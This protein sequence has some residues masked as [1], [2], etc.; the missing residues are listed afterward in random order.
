MSAMDSGDLVRDWQE[1][2][3]HVGP[4]LHELPEAA[5]TAVLQAVAAFLAEDAG[6]LLSE[7]EPLQYARAV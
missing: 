6:Q 1:E 4:R 7:S 2:L 3:R 5:R